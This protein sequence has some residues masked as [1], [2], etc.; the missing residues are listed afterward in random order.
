MSTFSF[1]VP[2]VAQPQAECSI[3]R[4]AAGLVK[5][6]DTIAAGCQYAAVL[7]MAPFLARTPEPGRPDEWDRDRPLLAENT[8]NTVL[9]VAQSCW[10]RTARSVVGPFYEPVLRSVKPATA[11]VSCEGFSLAAGLTD[12]DA[13]RSLVKSQM[14]AA[15]PLG[16]GAD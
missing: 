13:Q 12:I 6:G 3:A 14:V 7:N 8:S 1:P 4:W 15:G 9:L 10:P 2:A 11:F 5:D 16:G